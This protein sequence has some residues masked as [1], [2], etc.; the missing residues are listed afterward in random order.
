MFSE[1]RSAVTTISA[2]HPCQRC[3][4]GGRGCLLG[5]SC[6]RSREKQNAADYPV[7]N[8]AGTRPSIPR[9][10]SIR[11]IAMIPPQEPTQ[12]ALFV[13][14]PYCNFTTQPFT[15]QWERRAFLLLTYNGIVDR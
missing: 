13:D 8:A 15:V 5:N 1:R 2:D 11:P 4:R 9:D 10:L 3:R 14:A 12:V 6:C 7:P